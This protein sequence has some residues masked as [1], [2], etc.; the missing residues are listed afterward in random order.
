MLSDPVINPRQRDDGITS[1]R[2]VLVQTLFIHTLTVT[3]TIAVIVDGSVG[4]L[5]EIQVDV[6]A[7]AAISILILKRGREHI[8][9]LSASFL[10]D[11]N[12]YKFL[13]A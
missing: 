12:L 6:P 2:A 7:A 13:S 10:T 1:I 3:I 9:T 5:A 8:T 4:I 11:K